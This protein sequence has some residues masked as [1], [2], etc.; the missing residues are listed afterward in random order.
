MILHD[1]AQELISV[2]KLLIKSFD[3]G[4][5]PLKNTAESCS[6][7]LKMLSDATLMTEL[8]VVFV[9]YNVIV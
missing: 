9:F 3:N 5:M 4:E 8:E 1:V 6:V 7:S 2:C